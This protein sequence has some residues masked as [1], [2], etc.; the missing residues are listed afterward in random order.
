MTL[1]LTISVDDPQKDW[2]GLSGDRTASEAT[3]PLPQPAAFAAA[4]TAAAAGDVWLAQCG[5]WSELSRFRDGN[6]AQRWSKDVEARGSR[7]SDVFVW[8]VPAKAVHLESVSDAL[9]APKKKHCND[10][11]ISICSMASCLL[12]VCR[13]NAKTHTL[14]PEAP[15]T[16]VP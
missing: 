15:K 1:W 11:S 16:L 9:S 2:H 4:A 5:P 7:S 3:A 13:C 6:S 12:T 10:S 14:R 8:V